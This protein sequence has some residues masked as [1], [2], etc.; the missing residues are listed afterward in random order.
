[1]IGRRTLLILKD[2]RRYLAGHSWT[3]LLARVSRHAFALTLRSS[4]SDGR[5]PG[6]KRSRTKPM[7]ALDDPFLVAAGHVAGDGAE[8]ASPR[9]LEPSSRRTDRASATR[10]RVR[11]T[12]SGGTE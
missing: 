7:G 8:L 6:Q 5:H 2:E 3:R 9:V 11:S 12:W 4:R 10:M 1:V